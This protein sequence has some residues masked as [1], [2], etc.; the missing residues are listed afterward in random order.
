M[1]SCD[2]LSIPNTST[3]ARG[4]RVPE[5]ITVE[6]GK[7]RLNSATFLDGIT[8]E[9]S[10]FLLEEVGE[11]AGFCEHILPIIENKLGR[12]LRF[13]TISVGTVRSTGLWLNRRPEELFGNSAHVVI[14]APNAISKSQ[15]KKKTRELA[16]LAMLHP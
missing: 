1:A 7:E 5:W 12:K 3:L 4:V 15:Y 16:G 13:A 14:C 2:D 8:N 10:C 11:V 6:D 9:T